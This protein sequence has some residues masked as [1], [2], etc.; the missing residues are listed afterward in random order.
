MR[1]P[2]SAEF[3]E[4][5]IEGLPFPLIVLDSCGA[6]AAWNPAFEQLLGAGSLEQLRRLPNEARAEDPLRDFLLA[7]GQFS[8]TTRDGQN[9]NFTVIS[10]QLAQP[11]GGMARVFIDSAA[12][13]HSDSELPRPGL[14]NERQVLTDPAT[15]LL[16]LRGLLLALEPQVARSRR[17]N[18]Q[19]SVTMIGIAS[20]GELPATVFTECARVIRDQ[21]RWADLIGCDRNRTIILALPETPEDAAQRLAGKLVRL[22]EKVVGLHAAEQSVE[23]YWGIATWHKND[24][25]ASLLKRAETALND[26]RPRND[27]RTAAL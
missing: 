17:Y 19:I 21:V 16:N 9:V 26:K 25:A 8:W 22:V 3:A 4:A 24:N 1:E 23:V 15:G 12:E 27:P 13:L 7:S 6:I 14:E 2:L 5:I 20:R 10:F 18:R 11:N